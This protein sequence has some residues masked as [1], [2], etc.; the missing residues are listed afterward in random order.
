MVWLIA[1]VIAVI[2]AVLP[3]V[4]EAQR[5]GVDQQMRDRSNG[6]FAQLSAGVTHYRW[7]GPTDGPVIVA[8][9]G[10]TTPAIVWDGMI[11]SLTDQGFRVLSYDL[12]GRGLSGAPHG[13]QNIAF[14]VTQLRELLAD[15]EITDAVTLMGY[16]MGGSIVTAYAVDHPTVVSRVLLVASAGIETRKPLFDRLCCALPFIGDWL[17][18]SFAA[19]RVRR[20]AMATAKPAAITDM[21]AFQ[22]ARRGYLPAVLASQRGALAVRQPEAHRDLGRLGIPVVAVWGR[23]DKT[24]PLSAMGTLTT[25]NRNV[26][27]DEVADAGHGLPYSHS[28]ATARALLADF[29]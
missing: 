17:H 27:H 16:S 13:P 9:H 25:W 3:F 12:Y 28:V 10:L 5:R 20:G 23:L 7:H 1:A 22:L 21:Q 2:I 14:F 8:V 6:R 24:I 11:P 19:G 26:R 4:F 29:P 18:A 15:Q